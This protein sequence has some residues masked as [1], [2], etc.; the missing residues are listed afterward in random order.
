[1]LSTQ[2]SSLNLALISTVFLFSFT[3]RATSVE[4]VTSIDS[5]RSPNAKP[6]LST[7]KDLLQT[8]YSCQCR[9]EKLLQSYQ[10]LEN[11]SSAKAAVSFASPLLEAV[12]SSLPNLISGKPLNQDVAKR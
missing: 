2:V 10:T 8:D 9:R 12:A 1:M 4:G 3:D 11:V 7:Q 5:V 6:L